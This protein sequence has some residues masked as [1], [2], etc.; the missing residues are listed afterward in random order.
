MEYTKG[1]LKQYKYQVP[2][3]ATGV[4]ATSLE[5]A[6]QNCRKKFGWHFDKNKNAIVSFEDAKDAFYWTLKWYETN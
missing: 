5:W 3:K 2:L 4:S 6:N 1:Y